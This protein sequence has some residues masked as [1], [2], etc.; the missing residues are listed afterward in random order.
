MSCSPILDCQLAAIGDA[1]ALQ[2]KDTCTIRRFDM[3]DDGR[4]GRVRIPNDIATGVPCLVTTTRWQPSEGR[5]AERLTGKTQ[6]M[7]YLP[8]GQDVA[9]ATDVI[10][11]TSLSNRTFEVIGLMSASLEVLRMVQATEVL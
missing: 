8:P 10:I 7:I 3:L 4:G 9:A 11:V 6:W 5:H 2:L 1:L